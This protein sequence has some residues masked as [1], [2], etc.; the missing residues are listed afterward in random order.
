MGILPLS[1]QYTLTKL[2][3]QRTAEVFVPFGVSGIE[4]S[5]PSP[6][7]MKLRPRRRGVS[8]RR[9]N[10]LASGPGGAALELFQAENSQLSW[11][12]LLLPSTRIPRTREAHRKGGRVWPRRQR[13]VQEQACK[14]CFC[15]QGQ[16][17]QWCSQARR[18][19]RRWQR[20]SP[21]NGRYPAIT[22]GRAW[23]TS[24]SDFQ[25]CFVIIAHF[26]ALRCTEKSGLWQRVTDTVNSLGLLDVRGSKTRPALDGAGSAKESI[27]TSG[28]Q[29][30]FLCLITFGKNRR[31]RGRK[32]GCFFGTSKTFFFNWLEIQ[33]WKEN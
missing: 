31:E 12:K 11:F 15:W 26:E 13:L 24:G 4:S 1:K 19:E 7:G 6:S 8:R 16:R 33:P 23:K 3:F 27:L 20:S 21:M 18:K 10:V 5:S 17:G 9:W 2:T 30:V 28:K 14:T 25:W 32:R 29:W 22:A